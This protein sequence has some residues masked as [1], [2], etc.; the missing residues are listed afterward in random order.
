MACAIKDEIVSTIKDRVDRGE[1]LD[2]VAWDAV[3]SHL[4]IQ[5]AGGNT[6][7]QGVLRLLTEALDPVTQDAKGGVRS[8]AQTISL[9]RESL[10]V[11]GQDTNLADALVK[12]AQDVKNLD[13]EL[14]AG[15]VYRT[16]LAQE[17]TQT[18]QLARQGD[19]N[20]LNKLG[21]LVAEAVKVHKATDLIQTSGARAVNQGNYVVKN[22][23]PNLNWDAIEK[24]AQDSVGDGSLGARRLIAAITMADGDP[25]VTADLIKP[26]EQAGSGV[27]NKALSV[28][29]E[30][31]INSILGGLTTQAA[32]FTGN[33]LQAHLLPLDKIVGGVLTMNPAAIRRG[34]SDVTG[35]WG[36]LLS[37]F[38]FTRRASTTGYDS[39]LESVGKSFKTE[40]GILDA[41]T[42]MSEQFNRKAISAA[43]LGISPGNPLANTVDALGALVRMPTRVLTTA[44]ELFKQ[45]NYRAAVGSLASEEAA[46]LGIS[47]KELPGFLENYM[48]QSYDELGRGINEDALRYAQEA[49]FTQSPM[50][51]SITAD[52]MN[53]LGKHPGLRPIVPFVKVPTNMLREFAQYTP[54]LNLLQKNF[55]QGLFSSDPLV[56]SQTWGKLAVGGAGSYMVYQAAA[57]GSITGAGPVEPKQREALMSTGWRPYS[58]VVDNADGTKSYIDYRRIDPAASLIGLVADV[59]EVSHH[60]DDPEYQGLFHAITMSVA[61]NVTNRTYLRGLSEL[62]TVLGSNDPEKI[63]QVLYNRAGSYVPGYVAAFNDDP[64]MRDVRTWVD[65]IKRRVP[66]YSQTLPPRRD[67]FGDPMNAP[68]GWSIDGEPENGVPKAS[69]FGFSQRIGDPVKEELANVAQ[70][71]PGSDHGFSKPPRVLDGVHLPDFTNEKGQDAYD[72]YQELRGQVTVGGKTMTDALNKLINS[73]YYNRLP[74]AKDSDARLNAIQSV[75]RSYREPAKQQ[76]LQEYPQIKDMMDTINKHNRLSQ[77]PSVSR[78][79]NY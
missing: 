5:R 27:F 40:S 59:A 13:A 31:W 16:Q 56:K 45:A 54:G 39:V 14:Y 74:D 26:F 60:L 35:F 51:G 33:M 12:R 18:A 2:A 34:I 69:P 8:K 37:V 52:F 20:A 63:K 25:Q 17:L 57:N 76:L 11:H 46:R 61:Q 49:T 32:N 78:L 30:Y 73:G 55:R 58:F 28:H 15:R 21:P 41:S 43:N 48:R 75:I 64:Y 47:G 68:V 1:P 50:A 70:A 72:R 79:L 29:N 22:L 36:S 3:Q 24:A 53:F 23:I 65:A 19:Q 44:D 9:A 67:M 38:D 77:S 6:D 7:V 66:G 62:V 10:A 42:K 4:N 71:T